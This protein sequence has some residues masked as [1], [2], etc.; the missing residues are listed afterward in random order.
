MRKLGFALVILWGLAAGL[1]VAAHESPEELEQVL[2][3][4]E[5]AGFP[6]P[7]DA[8]SYVLSAGIC[9]VIVPLLL[10]LVIVLSTKTVGELREELKKS[11]DDVQVARSIL[12]GMDDKGREVE[13]TLATVGSNSFASDVAA[14]EKKMRG[15]EQSALESGKK[16]DGVLADVG[17]RVAA[18]NERLAKAQTAV[19]KLTD[20]DKG[21]R[22]QLRKIELG[23]GKLREELTTIMGESPSQQL[24]KFAE[25]MTLLGRKL[26]SLATVLPRA[27]KV[28]A[29][30]EV[31]K[32]RLEVLQNVP[33]QS[34]IGGTLEAINDDLI[35]L[36]EEVKGVSEDD[37]R[38]FVDAVGAWEVE[39]SDLK[40]QVEALEKLG[41]RITAFAQE[42][43]SLNDRLAKADGDENRH[44]SGIVDDVQKQK[45][46][47]ERD[48]KDAELDNDREKALADIVDEMD[49]D[50]LQDRIKALEDLG[51]RITAIQKALK[52]YVQRLEPIES[53]AAL[54]A[55]I[56]RLKGQLDGALENLV[57][58]TESA[59]SELESDSDVLRGR[60]ERFEEASNRLVAV[61]DGMVQTQQRVGDLD[62]PNG[63]P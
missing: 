48:L 33:G 39:L 49:I 46:K 55:G 16:Q 51:P 30:L 21:V 2:A 45:E 8:P 5:K 18:L 24:A 52:E 10:L 32:K 7:G 42:V 3:S 62:K 44:L 28:K 58:P 50:G 25:E 27:D 59:M 37:D 47:L 11:R 56:N 43:K 19:T 4:M 40:E 13:C 54:V 22:S 15:I 17:E 35:L 36:K 60:L 6:L 20:N 31:L 41:P 63:T 53:M 38:N 23:Q 12:R 1:L 26:D 9:V 29:D 34:D 61:K 57:L 14:F